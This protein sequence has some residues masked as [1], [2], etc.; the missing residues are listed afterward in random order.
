MSE[1]TTAQIL[2]KGCQSTGI[3]E[4]LARKYHDNLGISVMAIV[5]L[6]ATSRTEEADGKES[7]KLNILSV[8]P[9]NSQ[10]VTDH[11]R[12]LQRA[13]YHGRKLHD[14]D[15][16]PQLDGV[17]DVEPTVAEVLAQ[18]QGVLPDAPESSS[19]DDPPWEYPH[20]EGQTS[21]EDEE[22]KV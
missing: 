6:R 9:A 1:S 12:G 16:Q 2:A 14:E 15:S 19:A 20:G 21:D 7:V 8:E 13:M 3:T 4:E 5:E 22:A 10:E 11:L 17:D 18:G